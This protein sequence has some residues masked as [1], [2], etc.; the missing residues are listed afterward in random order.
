M[1]FADTVIDQLWEV[2]RISQVD[3]C[4]KVRTVTLGWGLTPLH[5]LTSLQCEL[6]PLQVLRQ[7]SEMHLNPHKGDPPPPRPDGGRGGWTCSF[8]NRSHGRE[9]IKHDMTPTC[10]H[11]SP[12]SQR[13]STGET[14]IFQTFLFSWAWVI[15]EKACF[16]SYSR[17][18][19]FGVAKASVCFIEAA[20]KRT[21]VQSKPE[22]H[23]K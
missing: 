21:N 11:V 1:Q 20:K 15:C 7:M 19:T 23:Q 2:W 3:K 16:C 13:P 22:K 12:S 9:L 8:L 4:E 10:K 6:W 18:T 17:R 5:T 14:D